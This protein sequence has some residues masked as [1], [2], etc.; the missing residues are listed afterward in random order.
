M[1]GS[2]PND[3]CDP[4]ICSDL[5]FPEAF[6]PDGD[7]INDLFVIEGLE[8]YP[9]HNLTIFNR[10]GDM[11]YSSMNYQNDWDGSSQNSLNFI[12][13]KLPTG[14]YYYLFDTRNEN[15]GIISGYVFL[16]R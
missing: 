3:P 1:D 6:T 10:W 15:I 12:N 14:T 8:I 11:V 4:N 13:D 2:D 9:D 5:I 16:Q 7:G